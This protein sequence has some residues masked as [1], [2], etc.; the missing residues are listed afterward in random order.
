MQVWSCWGV[1]VPVMVA[2]R[3]LEPSKGVSRLRLDRMLTMGEKKRPRGM[4][5]RGPTMGAKCTYQN[6][7]LSHVRVDVADMGSKIS[8]VGLR[9]AFVKGTRGGDLQNKGLRR[10]SKYIIEFLQRDK[11]VTTYSNNGVVRDNL[12]VK[13]LAAKGP[14]SV[15]VCQG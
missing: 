6:P 8:H 15:L 7:K 10:S 5:Y 12:F 11:E 3:G 13:S 9:V 1:S 4:F 2:G 14:T